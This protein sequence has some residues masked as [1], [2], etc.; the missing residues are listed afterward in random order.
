[1]QAASLS[2]SEI[3]SALAGAAGLDPKHAVKQVDRLLS[4]DGFDVWDVFAKWVPFV[5]GPRT[6]IVV[7]LDWTDFDRMTRRP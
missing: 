6:E 3:G 4:N 7:A 5:I 2:V 1:M